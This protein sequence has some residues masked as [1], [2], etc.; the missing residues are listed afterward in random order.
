MAEGTD[1]EDIVALGQADTVLVG[2]EMGVEVAWGGK[3]KGSL[4]EDLASGGFKEVAATDYFGDVGGGV[5]DD[6]G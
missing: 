5:V 4:E 1:G 6:T 2:E 3:Q